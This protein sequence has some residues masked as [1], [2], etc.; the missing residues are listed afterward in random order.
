LRSCFSQQ[1][2]SCISQQFQNTLS[3]TVSDS[4]LSSSLRP[5]LSCPTVTD[6]AFPHSFIYGFPHRFGSHLSE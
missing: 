2:R 3:L 5:Y 4:A 6:P 1:F